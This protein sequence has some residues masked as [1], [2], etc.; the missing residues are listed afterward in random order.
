MAGTSADGLPGIFEAAF[1][2]VACNAT[3]SKLSLEGR[4]H[5]R[6]SNQSS[7]VLATWSWQTEDRTAN[8]MTNYTSHCDNTV[9]PNSN[10]ATHRTHHVGMWEPGVIATIPVG[11]ILMLFACTCV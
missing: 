2:L 5:K 3:S 4:V 7:F 8:L 9:A 6:I 11:K 1:S 10:K